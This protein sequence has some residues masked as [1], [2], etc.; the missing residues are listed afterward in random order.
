MVWQ[1]VCSEDHKWVFQYQHLMKI[2]NMLS[3][4]DNVSKRL[5]DV[6]HRQKRIF[7]FSGLRNY[8]KAYLLS[9]QTLPNV[10]SNGQLAL[11]M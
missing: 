5:P 3:F 1:T 8:L 4:F 9:A 11:L 7:T 6:R 2:L 10:R